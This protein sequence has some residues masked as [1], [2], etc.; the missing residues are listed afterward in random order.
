MWPRLK[1]FIL[2]QNPSAGDQVL[3]M[4]NYCKPVIKKNKLPARVLNGLQ[5]DTIPPELAQLDS[6]SRQLIQRA[7]CYQ[8]VV[9]LGTYTGKVPVYNSLKAC[10]GTMFFLPLPLRKTLETLDQVKHTSKAKLA[11]P[12]PELYIIVNGRPTKSKVVWRTLV[13][14]NAVKTAIKRLREINWLYREVHD[15][16][17]DEAAKQVIEVTKNTSSTMLEKASDNDIAGFQ[18]FT[19]RN[20]DNKL[21]TDSD[22]EQYK[23]LSVKE[24][25]L[26]NRQQYLDVM[27]FPV[28]FPTGKFGEHHPREVKLSHSEYIKSRLLNR[29]SRF[30]KDPQYVFYLLWQKE[31][32]ELSA[33]VYN[34][35]KCTRS[36]PMSVSSL[37]NR[38]EASD[39]KLVA[40]L[41][42]MLQSVRGTKQYWFLRQSELRCMIRE[43][44]SPTLFL[45]FSCAEYESPDITNYLRKVNNVPSSYNIGRLCT[46]DPISVSSKFSLKFHA[47]FRTVLMKGD[48]LGKVDHFYWKKEY[49]ARGAPHY[50]VLLWIRDAP[51]IGVDD[52]EKVLGWIQEKITCHI[53]DKESN[54]ELHSLVTRYQM[55]K[56]SAYCKRKRKCGRSTFITRC[57]FGF[58]RQ[59]CENPKLNSV[60]DSLKTRNRIYQLARTD[61]E[62]RVND[63]NPLLLM[64]WKANIDIQFV[65]E[66]SLALA[67]YVS[68]YVTK[69]ERSNMQEIWEEVSENKSIYGRLWS[70]GVRSLRFRECGLYEA[71]DL[72]LGD[73]LNEKSVTV[74][75][76]DVSMPHKRNR[77]LKDHKVLQQIAQ[78]N[79]D[80]EDIFEDN[81]IDTF[82]PQRPA[83]LEGVCLYDFVANYD[84]QSRDDDGN[85]KY[86]KLT[87]PRLPNHKLFDLANELQR[88]LPLLS[89]TAVHS[90]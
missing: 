6:L 20:L 16:S 29:D 45:T 7:K 59:A 2:E 73:H 51:V 57:R 23:V 42:T 79:P 24:D 62:V 11:L 53:P 28:L 87:K 64:L 74:K 49:Q 12:N 56:C 19:I 71:S 84:W 1:S 36:Q 31:L 88:R 18:A 34:L 9:R 15:E 38:V 46:E 37:L 48:V 43:W 75:W 85:R 55:H 70:F 80:T 50:H 17:V 66:S 67:H 61:V 78:S 35:Q 22:T 90:V 21:S 86:R 25:A 60:Q 65:A 39:E 32:R 52:P 33:G 40:N 5:L 76:M 30:R 44:G 54:P 27:C 13:D 68:G 41:C 8:T 3:F 4:C 14:V 77:R 47:F 69:A 82:Y 89:I 83:T 72:L 26:D 81:L 58:P 63:F 10:K